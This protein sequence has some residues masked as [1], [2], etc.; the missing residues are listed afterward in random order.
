MD[1]KCFKCGKAKDINL[2]YKHNKMKDGFLNKCIDCTKYD[3]STNS[4]NYDR[5]EKGVIRVIYKTQKS[6]SKKRGHEKPSYTKKDLSYWLYS[7]GFKKIYDDWVKSGYE[8]NKKPSVDRI[9]DFKGYSLSNI[10]ICTW[11]DN[12][13]RGHMDRVNGVGTQGSICKAVVKLTEGNV[14]V[15]EYISLSSCNRIVGYRVDHHI[16]T[17]KKCKM[18]FYWRYK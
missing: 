13:M 2:F 12:M 4:N 17:K 6:N 9:D 18:G 1:K 7:N 8:K 16:K 14:I 15:D 11:G 5:T 10:K 3:V